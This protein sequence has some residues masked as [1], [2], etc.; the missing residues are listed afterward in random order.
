MWEI[1]MVRESTV[2]ALK[3]NP[4][5]YNVIYGKESLNQNI[6]AFTIL[7]RSINQAGLNKYVPRTANAI[8]EIADFLKTN[9]GKK[10][11]DFR[12]VDINPHYNMFKLINECK[13]LKI[14]GND[15]EYKLYK[16]K[17]EYHLWIPDKFNR[18]HHKHL[19]IKAKDDTVFRDKLEKL[20]N[21][22]TTRAKLDFKVFNMP[23]G[24]RNILVSG[25]PRHE[26]FLNEEKITGAYKDNTYQSIG[27]NGD[28]EQFDS[29]L[30]SVD[31][32][33][34]SYYGPSFQFSGYSD[35]DNKPLTIQD[36]IW[37]KSHEAAQFINGSN[38]C[39]ELLE[40]IVAQTYSGQNIDPSHAAQMT[41]KMKEDFIHNLYGF[42]TFNTRSKGQTLLPYGDTPK[43]WQLLNDPL[44]GGRFWENHAPSNQEIA[45]M[46]YVPQI[47]G[48][49][50]LRYDVNK[51]DFFS[52]IDRLKIDPKDRQYTMNYA[53][54]ALG[55]KIAMR[56]IQ[57]ELAKIKLDDPIASSAEQIENTQKWQDLSYI[58]DA[59]F[60][61]SGDLR[62]SLRKGNIGFSAYAEAIGL[63]NIPDIKGSDSFVTKGIPD[64]EGFVKTATYGLGKIAENYPYFENFW[65]WQ[66]REYFGRS[67]HS[68]FSEKLFNRK[69]PSIVADN[70]VVMMTEALDRTGR[71]LKLFN[72][73]FD[74]DADLG[75]LIKKLGERLNRGD[76]ATAGDIVKQQKIRFSEFFQGKKDY[77]DTA[78]K[79]L[80]LQGEGVLFEEEVFPTYKGS[81]LGDNNGIIDAIN[82]SENNMLSDSGGVMHHLY[83]REA[84]KMALKLLP[85]MIDIARFMKAHQARLLYQNQQTLGSKSNNTKKRQE[86]LQE[87]YKCPEMKEL[88]NYI[89]AAS[90]KMAL[91]YFD[92]NKT[93]FKNGPDEDLRIL[94]QHVRMEYLN[95]LQM[96]ANVVAMVA[97]NPE[98]RQTG[99]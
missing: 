67:L 65:G 5:R 74:R 14:N 17:D 49:A 43:N 82:L 63:E 11:T 72:D 31:R 81:Y 57:E 55:I 45:I 90:H 42:G 4:K 29:K 48:T 71:R 89:K 78:V 6:G 50:K 80:A 85:T 83:W 26:I 34:I 8:G 32:K 70:A 52:L 21:N 22:P 53:R 25:L 40:N 73:V 20:L 33:Q 44:R 76:Y 28:I 66:G 16:L 87:V 15:T 84:D 68:I 64:K 1:V 91:K 79:R 18:N 9:E 23:L 94:F 56:F 10:A 99:K 13:T 96:T 77:S 59:L 37:V 75:S 58:K 2:I 47:D 36:D 86:I 98:V 38:E 51:K 7:G 39:S 24:L 97:Y 88:D 92:K 30:G 54:K 95:L 35:R 69:V 3:N 19:H 41:A 61:N 46:M 60:N 12:I 62:D 93:S 27:M